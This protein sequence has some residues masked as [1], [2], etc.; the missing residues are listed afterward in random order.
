MKVCKERT[1]VAG[2]LAPESEICPEHVKRQEIHTTLLAR[3]E[4]PSASLLAVSSRADRVRAL[5]EQ[6]DVGT[7][8][9]DSQALAQRMQHFPVLWPWHPLA[10]VGILR[11][12]ED[13][14]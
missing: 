4:A 2:L 11:V 7:Y 1:G 3:E 14:S 12:G 13:E 8:V 9:I 10:T 5:K 6:V